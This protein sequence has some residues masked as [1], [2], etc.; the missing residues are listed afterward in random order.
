MMII[1]IIIYISGLLGGAV[2][3]WVAKSDELLEKEM[4][5]LS[6]RYELGIKI[7]ELIRAEIRCNKN[8]PRKS[9]D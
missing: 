7:D 2:L 6:L 9:K 3:M 5:I 8:T 4:E 1:K